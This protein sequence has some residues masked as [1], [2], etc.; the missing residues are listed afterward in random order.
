MRSM[1]TCSNCGRTMSESEEAFLFEQKVVCA[2]C[3]ADLR[4]HVVPFAPYAVPTLQPAGPPL[5]GP[6]R[7]PEERERPYYVDDHVQVTN[8]N[9]RVADRT[10]PL[11]TIRAARLELMPGNRL[12]AYLLAAT[13]PLLIVFFIL[14]KAINGVNRWSLIFLSLLAAG[15]SAHQFWDNRAEYGLA[16]DFTMKERVLF[17]TLDRKRVEAMVAAVNKAVADRIKE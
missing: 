13:A 7:D 15:G 16:I 12:W 4:E 11:E 3:H 6:A 5:K 9:L 1:E 8:F 17:H 14:E 10:Y 2:A